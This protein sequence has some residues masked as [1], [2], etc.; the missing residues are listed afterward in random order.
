MRLKGVVRASC[1]A[2]QHHTNTHLGPRRCLALTHTTQSVS[3]LRSREEGRATLA[4]SRPL[5]HTHSH[6]TLATAATTSTATV[7]AAATTAPPLPLAAVVP[8]RPRK[9]HV[10]RS[11]AA[12]IRLVRAEH[13]WALPVRRRAYLSKVI[14]AASTDEQCHEGSGADLE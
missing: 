10:Y 2:H 3:R 13:L 7:A 9:V 6:V 8:R 12:P 4:L 1:S 11:S 5:L 14:T